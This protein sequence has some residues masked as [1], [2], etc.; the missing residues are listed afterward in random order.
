MEA[1]LEA[2]G[3]EDYTIVTVPMANH[4]FQAATTGAPSEYGT[5]EAEFHPDVLPTITD[6]LLAHVDVA[7]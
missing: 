4:L 3:N 2:A 1:A 5:L 7:Q 6:W